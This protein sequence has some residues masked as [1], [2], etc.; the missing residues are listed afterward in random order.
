M[1]SGPPLLTL[2]VLQVLTQGKTEGKN[3][4]H[5]CF[6]RIPISGEMMARKEF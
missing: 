2:K 4:T 6:T 5:K 1:E 3:T